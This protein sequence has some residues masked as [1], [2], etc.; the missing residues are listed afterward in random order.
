MMSR[1]PMEKADS[2]QD[3]RETEAERWDSNKDG[4]RNARDHTHR[5]RNEES[6]RWARQWPGHSRGTN[7]WAS[8]QLNTIV[9][10]RKTGREEDWKNPQENTQ[11]L[12]DNGQP[13]GI[14]HAYWERQKEKKKHKKYIYIF[15]N[16]KNI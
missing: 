5:K 6:V 12:K 11:E 13:Q 9:Q 4:K 14:T 1:G 16:T 7:L 10:N 2:I 15:W 3:H 8:G